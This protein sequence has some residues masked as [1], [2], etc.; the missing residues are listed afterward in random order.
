M[1]LQARLTL[2]SVLI[3][4][5]IVT[6]VS[7][8][9]LG[10]DMERQFEGTLRSARSIRT[11]VS[12]LV[13]RTVERERTLSLRE[14]LRQPD[15]TTELVE[16]LVDSPA[17]LEIAVCDRKNEILVDSDPKRQG[18]IFK[19]YPD[20][21][22]VVNKA[23]W[24]EKLRILFSKQFYQI[25]QPLGSRSEVILYVRV[26]VAPALIRNDIY[27]ALVKN[28]TVAVASVVGAVIITLVFSTL[29]F[30]SLGRLGQ[31]LDLLASGQ[32][33]YPENLVAP[34]AKTDEFGLMASKV[35]LLG[36]Q[37]R[38][39]RYDFSDLRGNFER[40][41]DDLEDA[42][43]IF[44]RDR[45]L[46]IAS[47]AVERYLGRM[48]SDLL[49]QPMNEIF[50]PNTPVGLLLAQAAQTGRQIRNRR[51]PLATA[52]GAPG[53]I[54]IVLLSVDM[55][56]S[57]GAT[58][59][60]GRVPAIAVRLRDPE[61]TRQIGRQLQTADR[62]SAISRISGGV[63]HEVKNPLNAILMHVEVARM[64][65]AKG[66]MDIDPQMEIVSREILRLDRVVKTFLD[67]TR[68]V[69][70]NVSEVPLDEFMQEIVDLAR[71]Q[72]AFAGIEIG[73]DQRADGIAIRADRDLLKQAVLNVAVN[74]IEAM[75][76]GGSLR[77][78]SAL[79]NDEAEIRIAD[80]GPGIPPELREKIFR[81]YF[82]TKEGGS[83]IG[84]AMTFRIVQLH[85]GTIDFSS[86]PGKGTTFTM[87]FPVV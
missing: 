1:T 62:L 51:V 54:A 80:S 43:L 78:E 74:A 38:G 14:A 65:L 76:S 63:A 36:E 71:P 10:N 23:G 56:E 55:M 41:L 52:A 22:P 75:P 40:L 45:R 33:D 82:T 86:E 67:F 35:S 79:Q 66:D 60:S 21:A 81:L 28:A 84:L 16:D 46:V 83:G 9:D 26:V 59:Y 29:A 47:G 24:P 77:F 68:P 73:V 32:Y 8:V 42:I 70:L 4:T 69:E 85:D 7:V 57:L 48:R 50:P 20:F 12:R 27:P 6:I 11:A 87:R 13:R 34:P 15:I 64:K 18:S 49:N 37:L 53:S 44:G 25:E 5:V 72:A 58:G 2:S 19:E 30:R 17:V 31:M 61:A 3:T 39:A